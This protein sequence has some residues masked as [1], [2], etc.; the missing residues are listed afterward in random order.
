MA[1]LIARSLLSWL[2]AAG[3]AAPD[4]MPLRH[5]V[6]GHIIR[7]GE[8]GIVTLE[9]DRAFR[10]AGGQRFVLLEVADAEQ[11]AFVVADAAGN[12]QRFYWIQFER[13]LPGS[14]GTYD[15]GEDRALSLDGREWRAQVRRYATPADPASDRG[16]LYALFARAGL[17]APVPAIRARLVYVTAADRRAELMIVYAEA[18]ATDAAPTGSEIDAMIAR[19]RAGLT[20]K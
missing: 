14:R 6:E 17:H 2:L 19:A 1:S 4:T 12:V 11:H 5:A 9:V 15:Y 7:A 16:R 20:I 18:S 13:Y 8:G 3:T 10:Y